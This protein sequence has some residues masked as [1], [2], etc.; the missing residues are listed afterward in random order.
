MLGCRPQGPRFFQQATE[1]VLRGLAMTIHKEQGRLADSGA[2]M[3]MLKISFTISGH[4]RKFRGG[5]E[6]RER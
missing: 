1:N 5:M 2:G 3:W 4:L 6:K